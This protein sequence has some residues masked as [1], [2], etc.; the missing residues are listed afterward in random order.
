MRIVITGITGFVG[1][2]LAQALVAQGKTIV[3]LVRPNADTTHLSN[4]KIQLKT[5]D[6]TH[7]DTLGSL[8]QPGDWLIHAA[9]MLGQPGVPESAYHTLHVQGTQNILAAAA[10]ANVARVLYISSP[11]VLGPIDGQPA[12][13][14]TPLAP[15]NPYERSKAAAEKAALDFV[16]KGLPVII[17]RPEFIYGPGDTHVLGLFQAV[18]R[19]LFFYIG[20]GQAV[21]H[22]T[23]I[24]DAV[25]GML[26][27][28]E[29]GVPGQIYH[30]TGPRP[31]TFEEYGRTI[32]AALQVRPPWLRLP[33]FVALVG[34][35]KL[36]FFGKILGFTPPLS[37]TGVAFFSENRRFSWQKARQQ[38]GY[39][40]QIDLADGVRRTVAWYRQQ[41]LLP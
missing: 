31:V 3:G 16:D 27:C 6:V 10:R 28:L 17:A 25:R 2:A 4:P 9:G 11:G 24:D 19:G 18:Q 30:I 8:F 33:K 1:G 23:Y 14:T 39:Q 21:C 20:K 35:I 32:A 29:K 36:E 12:D 13:E 34:A 7:P 26:L 37:R 41:N 5:G 40:P 22:P 38:L 15:S